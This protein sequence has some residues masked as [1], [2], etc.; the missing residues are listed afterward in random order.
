MGERTQFRYDLFVSHSRA[1]RA[2]V[3]GYLLPALDLSP[4]RLI[5]PQGFRPGAAIVGEFERAVGSSRITLLVLSPAYL[6]DE[7][8]VLGEQLASYAS[9]ERQRGRLVPLILKPCELPLRL[10][11][12]VRLDCTIEADWEAEIA[13]LR[14]LLAQPEPGPEHIPC[15]YPGMVPF[16]EQDAPHFFGRDREIEVLRRQLRHQNYL[17]VIGP[18]GSGKSSLV[19][20]GLIPSLHAH[21]PGEWLICALRP[22]TAPLKALQE[23][24]GDL[25]DLSSCSSSVLHLQSRRLLVVIDQLEELFTQAPR[26]D[27]AG[28]IAALQ[29][30][31]QVPG[32]SLLLTLRADFY[33]DL[34]NSDLWPVAAEERLEITP[35]RGAALRE[36][37]VRPAGALGVYVEPELVERLLADAA[38]EPGV[39]PLLQ[40]AMALLWDKRARRLLTL[41]AYDRLGADGRSGL[42]VAMAARA[43]ATLAALPPAGQAMARRIL[44]RLVQF[45]EGRADTRRQQPVEALRSADDE[46]GLFER[47]LDHL[48]D[49]RLLTLS[50]GEGATGRQ[51]DLAHEALIAGWPT[52]QGWIRERRGAEQARR[53]LEAKASEW[54]R[55]GRGAGGLLDEVELREADRWLESPDATDLGYGEALPVLVEASRRALEAD[56]QEKEAARQRELALERRGRQR[57]WGIVAILGLLVL[58]GLTWLARQELLRQSARLEGELCPVPGLSVRLECNEVTNRRYALCVEAGRCSP[59]PR[60]NAGAMRQSAL[61]V[62]EV[63]ALQAAAFCGWIGRRLPT[64]AEWLAAATQDGHTPWPW[65]EEEP[66]PDRANLLY[67]PN[68]PVATALNQ[69]QPVGGRPRGAT[70]TGI[71]DLIGNAWEWTATP[72]EKPGREGATWDGDPATAPD[73]LI[74]KGGGYLTS[75]TGLGT[76]TD[77]IDAQVSHRRD[78]LGF[79]CIKGSLP[80]EA[81]P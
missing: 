34:M 20:A 74:M 35:L 37:I 46:P 14:A 7:W 50:G 81:H 30:L 29:K 70:P 44:L 45:G 58:I 27:W 62:T 6:A 33:P 47:T 13:R 26:P 48:A 69:I 9:V 22:G 43:D 21:Q 24:L 2:W 17:F 71:Q 59:P 78:D 25:V 28:F 3:Y 60:F 51:A 49:N 63:D 54:M 72:W 80:Q 56:R 23:A 64:H 36:A 40:E 11:F 68:S 38:D 1:D 42:A 8:A 31:R 66:A 19:F 15:P 4:E 75:I 77:P 10:D 55:L 16:A 52:L 79:R 41:H 53:R 12:R 39:L 18:S 61:P 76:A 5:T 67:E 57:L 32:C 73:R 65:G